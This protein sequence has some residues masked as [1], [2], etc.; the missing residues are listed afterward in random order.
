MLFALHNIWVFTYVASIMKCI[1]CKN[2]ACVFLDKIESKQASTCMF[3][4]VLLL[5]QVPSVNLALQFCKLQGHAPIRRYS[6]SHVTKDQDIAYK[7]KEAKGLDKDIADTNGD[8]A[9][10]Q[11]EF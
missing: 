8:K 6:W 10:V 7:T 1:V 11:E 9:T 2:V 3:Q 4:P 5:S